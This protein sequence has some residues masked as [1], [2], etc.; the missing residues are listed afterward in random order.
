MRVSRVWTC[1][2]VES[3]SCRGWILMRVDKYDSE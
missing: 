1:M 2:R 3:V